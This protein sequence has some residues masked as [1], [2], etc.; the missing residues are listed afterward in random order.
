M[1]ADFGVAAWL[2][3]GKDSS[4][5]SVRH[6]FVGTPC[7]MAP[8]VMEQVRPVQMLASNSFKATDTVTGLWLCDN[9]LFYIRLG[10]M[11]TLY[12]ILSCLM[13]CLMSVFI[14]PTQDVGCS[15]YGGVVMT[16]L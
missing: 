11:L 13:E 12:I 4:R 14:C 10:H 3:T 6:T 5:D 2:A 7:W 16:I 9:I 1:I 15:A 8:E